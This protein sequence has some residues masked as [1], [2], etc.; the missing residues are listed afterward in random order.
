MHVRRRIPHA[1]YADAVVRELADRAAQFPGRA[2]STAYFGGGTPGLWDAGE[3]GRVLAAI[4]AVYGLPDDAE[5][6]VEV[7]PGEIDA[8]K[9]AALR[10]HGV[11]RLSIGAQSFDDRS[12]KVLGRT[13]DARAARST[14][15]EARRA[16]YDNLSLD[17][18]FGLPQQGREALDRELE[19]LLSLEVE[20]LSVYG[21][22]IEPRTAFSALVKSRALELPDSERQ[23]E[24]YERTRQRLV[25]AGY[26]HHEISSF[27][28]PGREARH[29]TLYW[30]Q[31]EYLGVGSSS[32]SLRLSSD[33]GRLEG[34]RFSNHRSV[35][36]YLAAAPRSTAAPADD[37]RTADA[38]R[39][40]PDALEREALWLSLRL[41]G[42]L[43]RA[44]HLARFGRDA[45]EASDA[46][47]GL[48]AE[49]LVEVASGRIRLTGRGV[50]FA[51]E[52]GAR[53]I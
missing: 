36:R 19:A 2:A 37:P 9:L 24:L 20:H 48:V 31:A 51:D 26:A 21:L 41:V 53:L 44:R 27:A 18:I 28:R 10:A 40:A 38:E 12:L 46:W 39:L 29:N 34:E 5:V 16:G 17:L 50:L 52:V 14:V 42:G 8:A 7:N 6:T 22:T 25:G 4:R 23:A 15:A 43:D 33:G 13:H 49:G 35:D 47:V 30:T 3:L 11:N 1:R 45:L 32:H